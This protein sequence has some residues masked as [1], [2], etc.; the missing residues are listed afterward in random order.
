VTTT[1][2][3]DG[4]V[5]TSTVMESRPVMAPETLWM[6]ADFSALV[7]YSN[8][9]PV[10]ALIDPFWERRTV[11]RAEAR[12]A[13][14]VVPAPPPARPPTRGGTPA[15]EPQRGGTDLP[16]PTPYQGEQKEDESSG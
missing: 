2:N 14:R 4:D 12:A 6:L 1:K 10:K 11:R 15:P 7:V 16:A 8:H 3:K 13:R 9:R 5:S